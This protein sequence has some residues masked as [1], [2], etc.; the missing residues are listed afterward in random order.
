MKL[1]LLLFLII[2][3]AI[4]TTELADTNFKS[5]K[6]IEKNSVSILTL[7]S[8]GLPFWF[9]ESTSTKR[10][11]RL[12]GG[13]NTTDADII[14]LQETFNTHLREILRKALNKNLKT[15]NDFS[16]SRKINGLISM[17]CHGGLITYSKYTVLSEKFFPFPVEDD[18]SLIERTGRKGFLF[19][20][21]KIKGFTINVINTHLYSGYGKKAQ[22]MRIKQIRFIENTIKNL[23]E[24]EQNPTIFA[25]DFNMQH[26]DIVI[27]NK[28]NKSLLWEYFSL[29]KSL[30]LKESDQHI[31]NDEMT[32]D[33]K[34]NNYN[35][36]FEPAQ[37]LDYVFFRDINNNI[38]IIQN[39]VLFKNENS[40][41]D[42]NAYLVSFRFNKTKSQDSNQYLA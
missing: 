18:Y 25:G 28:A 21:I 29:V 11:F 37:K 7:N 39:R 24:Y 31:S 12:V 8:W 17:D 26:P 19:S 40:V 6:K 16:C 9:K 15:L 33:S 34:S 4:Q 23:K 3:A 5:N 32:F 20:V 36:S 41:S 2:P 13:L 10:Y 22:Q 42:H 30:S 38:D 27:K 35:S 14:C 1:L